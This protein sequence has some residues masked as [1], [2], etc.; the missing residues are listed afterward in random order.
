MGPLFLD[1]FAAV[2]T[3]RMTQIPYLRS[4][5]SSPDT[6]NTNDLVGFLMAGWESRQ[7]FEKGS[8]FLAESGLAGDRN[9]CAN[10][11]RDVWD[12]KARHA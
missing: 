4:T 11:K 5:T 12:N 10:Q 3:T 7:F 1:W 6:S 9:C 8:V 2:V